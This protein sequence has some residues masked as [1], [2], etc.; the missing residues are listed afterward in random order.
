MAIFGIWHTLVPYIL[1]S[2]PQPFYSFR[3]LK[4]HTRIRI[5]CGLH[6]R[7]WAG[8]WRNDRAAVRAV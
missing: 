8:F 5:A 7:S 2:N 3:G 6:S 1:E 4:N